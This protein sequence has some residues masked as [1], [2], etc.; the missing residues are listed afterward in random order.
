[1]GFQSLPYVVSMFSAL[2]WMYYA[3]IK[4]GDTFLL[5]TINALG[6]LVEFIYIII[7]L[8]YATPSVKVHMLL[9]KSYQLIFINDV[10]L[11]S[12]LLRT[13]AY[14]YGCECYDGV[15]HCNISGIVLLLGRSESGTSCGLDLCWSFRLCFCSTSYHSGQHLVITHYD[16]PSLFNP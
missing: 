3:F 16:F 9:T 7:F 1:M 2:L 15:V 5:I 12:M 10:I 14:N 8:V 11:I 13:E 4:K 6:S